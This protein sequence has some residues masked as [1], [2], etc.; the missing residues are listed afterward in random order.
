[1]NALFGTKHGIISVIVFALVMAVVG[2]RVVHKR[3][4]RAVRQN[5]AAPV[6]TTPPV[7][8]TTTPTSAVA[9]PTP[10]PAPAPGSATPMPP[11]AT[12]LVDVA[13]NAA[14]LDQYYHVEHRARKEHDQQGNPVTH[15]ENVGTPPD[16]G[17]VTIEAPDPEPAV[18]MTPRASLRLQG[19][20]SSS[21]APAS[22]A[23]AA[24]S[25]VLP[26]KLDAALPL[27]HPASSTKA[28]GPTAPL[29][30]SKGASGGLPAHAGPKRFNPY[31]SVIKCELLF[32]IDST[33]EEVPLVGVVME[34]IYN[35]GLQVIPA[36]AELHGVARPDRHRDRLFS[37]TDWMLVFP[38]EHG[39]INGREM[40]VH[41]VALDRVEP[42][43][44]GVTWGL[45]DGSYGLEGQIIRTMQ[46]DEIK[47]FV[48][49]FLAESAQALQHRQTDRDGHETAMNTPQ[50][51]ALQ[52][53]SAN[54]ERVA[55]DISEEIN[56][57][58]VFIRVPAGHQ[59]YFYPTQ[60]I[61]ADAATVPFE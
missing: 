58:G 24:L 8:A 7:A 33:A 9:T 10:Y 1:M 2:Y 13:E 61:D 59:F 6:T 30:A 44:S 53:L 27:P 42:D 38:R 54:L 36:G 15:R 25:A 3:R 48:A 50:N 28:D 39:G 45:T 26:T 31:G 14:F 16:A 12:P 60:V 23:L 20:P 52:G 40:R 17:H 46:E 43:A 34:P 56:R 29:I 5:A 22:S 49:T 37:T 21:A 35:N 47:R 4:D 32:T 51:A 18:S 19:H 57:N 55:A 41:G 11:P